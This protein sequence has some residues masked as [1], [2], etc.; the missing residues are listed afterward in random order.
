MSEPLDLMMPKSWVLAPGNLP[1]PHDCVI[2]VGA[3]ESSNAQVPIPLGA[4]TISVSWDGSTGMAIR[5]RPANGSDVVLASIPRGVGIR[6]AFISTSA[7]K[8]G[9]ALRFGI[10]EAPTTGDVENSQCAVT[11]LSIPP[12]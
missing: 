9:D 4:V 10:T 2:K 12:A 11:L 3:I 1:Y 5:R 7:R 6:T 8:S